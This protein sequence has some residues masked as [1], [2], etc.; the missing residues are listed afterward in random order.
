MIYNNLEV[1]A[2]KAVFKALVTVTCNYF[3]E[4]KPILYIRI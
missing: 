4:V 2:V 1:K 3:S